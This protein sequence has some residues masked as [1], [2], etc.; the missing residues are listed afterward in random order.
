MTLT[1]DPQPRAMPAAAGGRRAPV[2]VTVLAALV[3]L[4]AMVPV[5]YVAWYSLDLGPAA[6]WE[7][8]SRPRVGELLGN[9]TMLVVGVCL[10]S[11]LLG[12]ATAWLV[13]ATDLPGTWLWH[14]LLVA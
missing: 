7:L 10:V 11:T 4:G 5:G 2:T 1:L 8:L 3:A 9:T 12:S 13:E 6:T 14:G